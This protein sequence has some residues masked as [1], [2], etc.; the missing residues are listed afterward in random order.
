MLDFLGPLVNPIMLHNAVTTLGTLSYTTGSMVLIGTAIDLALALERLVLVDLRLV[1]WLVFV[2]ASL[3]SFA[4]VDLYRFE[5]L[6]PLRVVPPLA[7]VLM[8]AGL[9]A[10]W[11]GDAD[12]LT[13]AHSVQILFL[14]LF[15]IAFVLVDMHEPVFLNSSQ[16]TIPLS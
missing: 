10:A 1:L 13:S 4:F 3:N 6:A 11:T 16:S 2:F 5:F 12:L 9:C 15:L 8:F 7:N 14:F